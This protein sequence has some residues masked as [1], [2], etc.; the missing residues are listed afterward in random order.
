MPDKIQS[1]YK[2]TNIQTLLTGLD[3]VFKKYTARPLADFLTDIYDL[4]TAAGMGLD[5]WGAVLD[6]PRVI[7]GL[8]ENTF[9]T[10]TDDQYRVILKL[11]ALQTRTR[12]TIPEI[13]GELA[14]LFGS[15]GSASYAVDKQD[16]T[17]INYVFVWKIPDWL[18]AAFA[19]YRLL[20]SPMGVGTGF[21]EA[22]Y[23]HIGFE[24]QNLTSFYRAIFSTVP[25]LDSLI[26]GFEGQDLGNFEN[27]LFAGNENA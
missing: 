19:N 7:R 5:L 6:F 17:Y 3:R 26:I 14:G 11:L 25:Q 13:N 18:R 4:N 21:E 27:S 23:T 12:L 1:Q 2:D 9:F 15:F 20:P 16:M 8:E 10:L 22:L 24:G